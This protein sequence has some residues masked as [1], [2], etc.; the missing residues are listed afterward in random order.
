MFSCA[1]WPIA[2]GIIQSALVKEL[3]GV[4]LQEA[5]PADQSA[6]QSAKVTRNARSV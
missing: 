5:G 6:P 3:L 2:Q 1:R 4:L